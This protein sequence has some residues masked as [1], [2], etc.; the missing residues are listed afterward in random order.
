MHFFRRSKGRHSAPKR[1]SDT[2]PFN[3]AASSAGARS[4]TARQRQHA[5]LQLAGQRRGEERGP[6]T[7]VHQPPDPAHRRER[8]AVSTADVA[9]QK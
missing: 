5:A 3:R 1:F 4:G 6:Q 2:K 7:S 8:A 9:P